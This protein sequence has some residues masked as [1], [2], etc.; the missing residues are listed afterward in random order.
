M[1]DDMHTSV[2]PWDTH[3]YR[4]SNRPISFVNPQIISLYSCLNRTAVY[5]K[6]YGVLIQAVL[7]EVNLVLH[8]IA[9]ESIYL[10]M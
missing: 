7:N 10:R 2:P 4:L 9:D 6:F 1:S 8:H 5:T 3:Q